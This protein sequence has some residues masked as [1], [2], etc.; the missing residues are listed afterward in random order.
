MLWFLKK[1]PLDQI[2]P[3]SY[4]DFEQ[5]YQK[6]P[7]MNRVNTSDFLMIKFFKVLMTLFGDIDNH[8]LWLQNGGKMY[9]FANSFWNRYVLCLAS[10]MFYFLCSKPFSLSHILYFLNINYKILFRCRTCRLLTYLCSQQ[11]KVTR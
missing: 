6:D 11:G 1:I 8:A 10:V 2:F 5:K 4:M 3:R 9:C 7:G